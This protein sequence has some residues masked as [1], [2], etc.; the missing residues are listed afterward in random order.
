MKIPTIL[1]VDDEQGQRDC[2]FADRRVMADVVSHA[3]L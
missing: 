3:V 1:L 2:L